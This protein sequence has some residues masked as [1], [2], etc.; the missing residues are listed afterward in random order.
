M[1]LGASPNELAHPKKDW[2]TH[3]VLIRGF[4]EISSKNTR[5]YIRTGLPI[6]LKSKALPGQERGIN[7]RERLL[8]RSSF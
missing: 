3:L 7:K 1:V 4:I 2:K 5:E 8:R 6:F